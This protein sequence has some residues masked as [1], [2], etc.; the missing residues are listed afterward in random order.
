MAEHSDYMRGYFDGEIRAYEQVQQMLNTGLPYYAL[1]ESL[2]Q[3]LETIKELRYP[4][5]EK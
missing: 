1:N 5:E 4:E 3:M 2:K